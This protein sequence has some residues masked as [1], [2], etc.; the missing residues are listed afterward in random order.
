MT[1]SDHGPEELSFF[2]IPR[3]LFARHTRFH[4]IYIIFLRYLNA[5][6]RLSFSVLKRDSYI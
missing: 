1:T 2:L 6:S 4:I 5:L 3:F